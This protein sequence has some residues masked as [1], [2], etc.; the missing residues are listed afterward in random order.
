[1]RETAKRARAD[2]TSVLYL[3]ELRKQQ[4]DCLEVEGDKSRDNQTASVIIVKD[5]HSKPEVR[6]R[7]KT[8]IIGVKIQ[9]RYKRQWTK[10][11]TDG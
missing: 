1:M 5:C 10:R 4:G 2:R 3:T 6:P 7:K 9:H 11:W 8:D